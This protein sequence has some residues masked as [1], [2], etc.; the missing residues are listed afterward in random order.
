MPYNELLDRGIDPDDYSVHCYICNRYD[1]DCQC[2]IHIPQY[3]N[4]CKEEVPGCACDHELMRKEMIAEL[5][6]NDAQ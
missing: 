1:D 6:E 5:E 3:C 2:D 4:K